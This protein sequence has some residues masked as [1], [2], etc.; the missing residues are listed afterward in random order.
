MAYNFLGLVNDVCGRVNETPLTSSN[1]AS[2]SGI[3]STFKEAVN[4]SVRDINQEQFQWPFN[5][6]TYDETLTA[7]DTRYSY[8][9]DAKHVDFDTFRIQ[10]NSSFG[11][12]TRHLQRITYEEYVQKGGIDAEYNTSDTGIR[13]LPRYVAQGPA[14]EYVI[15]PAPDNAYTLSY[16]YYQLPTDMSAYDDVPSIPQSFAH[17][18][19]DGALYYVYFFHGDIEAADRIFMKFQDGIDNMRSIYINRYDYVRDTR[20]IRP[21]Y[22]SR[23]I[24]I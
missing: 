22:T 20:I 14:Q 19:V 8:Q 5:H 15:W 6:T 9:S 11:N 4:S 16:E 3:Y 13:A 7:G 24:D 17:I 21:G 1:F 2:S 10:R 12:T 18:I 23:T